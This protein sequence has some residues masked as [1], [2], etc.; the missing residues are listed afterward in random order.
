[1][2]P[3]DTLYS[4]DSTPGAQA[5]ETNPVDLTDITPAFSAIVYPNGYAIDEV[6]IQVSQDSAFPAETLEWD[7]P[8]MTISPT[9]PDGA[10]DRIADQ[11]Y[12]QE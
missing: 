12:G 9:V 7:S 2:Q 4:N 5:G 1:M 11:E 6:K 10:G 3:P 8:W